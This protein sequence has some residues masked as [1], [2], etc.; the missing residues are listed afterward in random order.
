MA[1]TRFFLKEGAEVAVSDL[2][3]PNQLLAAREELD[4]YVAELNKQEAMARQ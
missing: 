3:P 1:A 4:R 2:R